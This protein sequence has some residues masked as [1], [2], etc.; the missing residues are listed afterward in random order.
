MDL[1]EYQAKMVE[2]WES[3]KTL[4]DE[5]LFC[6]VGMAEEAGECL[7]KIK[8]SMR[9]ERFNRE[10]YLLELGDCLAYWAMGC[11]VY[12]TKDNKF[13]FDTMLKPLINPVSLLKHTVDLYGDCYYLLDWI[14]NDDFSNLGRCLEDVFTSIR[15][16]AAK[17]DSTL[18]EVMQMNLDKLLDRKARL[19]TL[20][21]SGD[22]R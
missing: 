9:G 21:G 15:G 19:G 4:E 13:S 8:R 1:N 17:V 22:N 11:Y 16:C 3:D 14:E 6:C 18:S 2:I 7:G 20:R 10:G 12:K 5:L